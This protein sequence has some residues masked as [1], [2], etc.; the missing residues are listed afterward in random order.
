MKKILVSLLCFFTMLFTCV[1]GVEAK[2]YE[3]AYQK[4]KSYYSSVEQLTDTEHFMACESLGIESDKKSF[5]DELIKDDYSSDIAKTVILLSLHGD[6]PNNYKGKNYVKMLEDCVHDNGAFDKNNDSTYANYQ[7]FGVYALYVIDSK[8]ADKAADYL[9]GL[10]DNNG[11]FGSSYGVSLDITGWVIDALSLVNKDKYSSVINKSIEYIQSQQQDDGSYGI[12]DTYTMY[13]NASTQ[14]CVLM[15][16]V[17]YDSSGIQGDKYSKNGHH[18]YDS[19]ID[20]QNSNGSFWSDYT[21]KNKYDDY[22]TRQGA[23]ALGYY[24]NG[25]VLKKA[26]N[27]Y[28]KTISNNHNTTT[29]DNKKTETQNNKNTNKKPSSNKQKTQSKKTVKKSQQAKGADTSDISDIFGLIM[30][31]L[32]SGYVCLRGRKYFE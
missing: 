12:N 21:G 15:G 17:S 30:L 8:K 22:S 7:V 11:G 20:F 5:P 16:L 10:I 26:R 14:A 2:S 3:E 24:I 18:P 29:D 25:S 27:D 23:L 32:V 9:A 1:S 13:P 4:A 6:N 31:M 19:L 28:K